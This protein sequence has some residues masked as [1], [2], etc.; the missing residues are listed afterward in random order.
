MKLLFVIL[1][2]S[3]LL[4]ANGNQDDKGFKKYYQG[5][6]QIMDANWKQGITLL[7]E[8]VKEFPKSNYV[9]D[10]KYWIAYATQ[11]LGESEQAA[12]L[13]QD[14][15]KVYASSNLVENAERNLS[16]LAKKLAAKG[17][18]K[19]S[20]YMAKKR[21]D[22]ETDTKNDD[23][24]LKE[25][26]LFAISQNGGQKAAEKL[27]S[28]ALDKSNSRK[29]REKALFWYGQMS[30]VTAKD[31]RGLF[32]T[33]DSEQFQEQVIFGISQK[34]GK[35]ATEMLVELFKNPKMTSN[36]REKAL[37]W[38]GQAKPEYFEKYLPE[39]ME[40]TKNDSKLREKLMFNI[41]QSQIKEK[42][43]YLLKFA[44]DANENAE[45]REKAIFWLGQS[46]DAFEQLKKIYAAI[47]EPKLQEKIIFSFS[48]INTDESI[49]YMIKLLKMDSTS[50]S[51]KK[52]IVFWLGQS[53][54]KKAQ[55]AILDIID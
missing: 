39:I 42:N 29:I 54:S 13:F 16:R 6:Q 46:K 2:I 35:E 44:L 33:A 55:D 24:E 12:E 7:N 14:F 5:Y 19:Y 11:E 48:Q 38:I 30:F 4:A 9:D 34:S 27:K 43:E 51:I 3:C 10:A 53:Q 41:S 45:V 18:T 8:M 40:T 1:S 23:D 31:L 36:I 50:N 49:D 28:V 52:K 26:A 47:N 17:N 25:S 20:A 32:D 22:D 15:I 21:D 37:F